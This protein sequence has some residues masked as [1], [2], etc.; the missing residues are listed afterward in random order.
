MLIR[1]L[2]PHPVT[3]VRKRTLGEDEIVE[4]VKIIKPEAEAARLATKTERK[5]SINGVPISQ[6]TFSAVVGLPPKKKG[7]ILIVSQLVRSYLDRKQ[8]DRT[9]AVVPNEI[10]RDS[11]GAVLGAQ[12]LGLRAIDI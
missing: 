12:S 8:P 2:T 4:I 6:T 9:D 11:R 3:I 5:G 10:V 1:N 7:V